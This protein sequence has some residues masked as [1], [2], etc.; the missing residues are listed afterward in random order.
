MFQSEIDS[1]RVTEDT[2]LSKELIAVA[3][4][5]P[6]GWTAYIGLASQSVS[7]VAMSGSKLNEQTA[8]RIF[9]NVAGTYRG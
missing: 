4:V 5:K 1:T 8:R 2:L 3:I 7:M 9:S 6:N